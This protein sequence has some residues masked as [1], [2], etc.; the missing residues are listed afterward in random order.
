MQDDHDRRVRREFARQAEAYAASASV[1]RAGLV[2]WLPRLAGAAAGMSVLDVA[3]GPGH[4]SAALLRRG[5]TVFGVDLTPET[6]ALARRRL[7]AGVALACGHARSLPFRDGAFDLSVCRSSF[8]HLPEPAG[9]LAEMARCARGG[10]LATLDHVTSDDPG[11][12]EWHDAIER[13]RDPS[14]AACLSLSAW[15]RLYSEA[16]LRPDR[17]ERAAFEFDFEEWYERAFQGPKVKERVRGLLLDH[18]R[19][20]VTGMRVARRDP[21]TLEF[22][23][24][25][26]SAAVS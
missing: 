24:L 6:L 8:H 18:P 22:D 21:L 16:G 10:R 7:G 1:S 26:L 3:C 17:E 15:R 20:G 19:G 4:V 9:A 14:H 25:A 23:F 11:E 2:D 12:A 5:C 13:L